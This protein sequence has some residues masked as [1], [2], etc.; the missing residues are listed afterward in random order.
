MISMMSSD[1]TE[2]EDWL[3]DA[4]EK[5]LSTVNK[6]GNNDKNIEPN[7]ILETV[8]RLKEECVTRG[9]DKP[10]MQSDIKRFPHKFC[11]YLN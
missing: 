8:T 5:L 11:F 10:E 7:E 9:F 3:D 1:I 4:A 2:L 6:D